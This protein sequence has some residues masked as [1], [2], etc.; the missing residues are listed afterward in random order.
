M[1]Q[2]PMTNICPHCHLH[3]ANKYVCTNLGCG[4]R[5][6]APVQLYARARRRTPP[7]T[8]IIVKL[9]KPSKRRARRVRGVRR[10]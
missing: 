6:S 8:L 1:P 5:L 7:P 3:S 4:K 10:G 2:S 9:T